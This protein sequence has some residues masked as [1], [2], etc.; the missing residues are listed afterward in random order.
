MLAINI[1]KLAN[2]KIKE[3]PATDALFFTI[4]NYFVTAISFVPSFVI[5][6]MLGPLAMGLYTE[7]V[8]VLDY[9]RFHHLGMIN[10]MEREVPF[11]NGKNEFKKVEEVKKTTFI[12]I[13][14]TAINIGTILFIISFFSGI[15]KVGFRFLTVLVLT[16]TIVSF[17]E[18]LLQ[19]Y[20]RFRLWSL[21][22][23]VIGISEVCLKV[24]FVIKFGFNGLLTVMAL[25]GL[26]SIISYH[27]WGNCR[28]DFGAKIYLKEVIRLLKLGIPLIF[29]RLMY[30]LSISIDKLVIIFFLGRL[31]LGYYSIATMVSNYLTLMPKFGFRT[32]Y[33]RFMEDFGKNENIED[34]KKYLIKPNKVFGSLFAVLIGLV[35]IIIPFFVTYLL[36][37]F[38]EGIFAAQIVA[39]TAFFA[40]LIYTWHCFLIALYEQKKLA[41]LY[42]LNAAIAFII[43]LFFVLVIRMQINGVALATLVSQFIFT[44]ILISYSYRFY[45]KNLLEHLKLLMIL[46]LPFLW[47]MIA[48]LGTKFCY[49]R[50][51]SLKGD[52]LSML[53][54]CV[55][56]LIFSS[57]LIYNVI[58]N[59]RLFYHIFQF[60]EIRDE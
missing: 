38:K 35:V 9:C 14:L 16:E 21:L 27:I 26:I 50:Q 1:R 29:F 20:K 28:V 10:A 7:L 32:L 25:I 53:V 2:L 43:S 45:T 48:M 39:L 40:S 24:F 34:V 3:N 49:P 55:I 12:F 18:A 56:F 30:L 17:Y 54:G 59:E 52:L 4:S 13:L 58:K 41:L 31:Q 22:L 6:K 5:R 33:P 11:Y 42:G 57:P 15:H 8:L 46:Y 23:V 47:I 51:I 36:S 44:T 19:S 60:A 37:R